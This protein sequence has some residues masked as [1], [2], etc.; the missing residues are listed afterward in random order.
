MPLAMA[1]WSSTHWT[2]REFPYE[3]LCPSKTHAE[4]LMPRV[5]IL[6]GGTSGR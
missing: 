3:Y 5:M 1:I 2:V 6:I 4:N